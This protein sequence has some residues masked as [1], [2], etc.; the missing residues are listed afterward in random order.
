MKKLM[1]I[2]LVLLA[3]AG[4]VCG[5]GSPLYD[6]A[7]RVTPGGISPAGGVSVMICK[8]GATLTAGICGPP[9]TTVY[10]CANFQSVSCTLSNPITTDTNGNFLVYVPSGFYEV[11]FFGN[12]ITP[13][14]K[15][16]QASGRYFSGTA[17]NIPACTN[18][19]PNALYGDL[20]S[21]VDDT[22]TYKCSPSG[23]VSVLTAGVTSPVGSPSPFVFNVD[24]LWK[25]P[26]PLIDIRAFGARAGA[27]SANTSGTPTATINSGSNSVTLTSSTCTA[28][29]QCFFSNINN[30]GYG[31]GVVIYGAGA[32]HS[33]STPSAPTLN[34]GILASDLGVG[35]SVVGP[36]GSNTQRC[37]VIAARDQNQGLTAKS[38]ES[39]I[40]TYQTLGA[41]T[42]NATATRSNQQIT[43]TVSSHTLANLAMVW[44]NSCSDLT[45]DGFFTVAS[46]TGT[47]LVVN[48]GY[49]AAAA[50]PGVGVSATGCVLTQWNDVIV[51]L[52][53]FGTG[54]W[55]YAIYE[56]ASS[57]ETLY[58]T[59]NPNIGTSDST[60]LVFEDMGSAIS[61]EA[62][63]PYF[64]PNT[65]PSAATSDSLFCQVGSGGGTTTMTLLNQSGTA[66]NAGTSVS[67][68]IILQDVGFAMN[69]AQNFAATGGGD[70]SIP[71]TGFN[72]FFTLNSFLDMNNASVIQSGG[73]ALNDT[74]EL[75]V[76]S[77]NGQ[78]FEN[79]QWKSQPPNGM[80]GRTALNAPRANPGIYLCGGSLQG[81]NFVSAHTNGTGVLNSCGGG[82][83]GALASQVNFYAP[84][85]TG[86]GFRDLQNVS[87]GGFGFSMYDVSFAHDSLSTTVP[88]A[89]CEF[90]NDSLI[91][92][93]STSG[94]RVGCVFPSTQGN[95]F[96]LVWHGYHDNQMGAGSFG[97]LFE[98]SRNGGNVPSHIVISDM[99]TDSSVFPQVVL[100]SMNGP[101]TGNYN[102]TLAL[103]GFNNPSISGNPFGSV[104]VTGFGGGCSAPTQNVNFKCDNGGTGLQINNN[105]IQTLGANGS[106]GY[107]LGQMSN[108]SAAPTVSATTS[109]CSGFPA[110]GS[111]TFDVVFVDPSEAINYNSPSHWTAPSPASGSVSVDGVTQCFAFTRPAA[112][113]GSSIW[114]VGYNP[115]SAGFRM[116]CSQFNV[117]VTSVTISSL[118][119]C[120]SSVPQNNTTALHVLSTGG[121]FGAE[122][123]TSEATASI[124]TSAASPAV[125]SGSYEGFVTI[126]AGTSSIVVDT[127]AVTSVSGID[128]DFDS[129]VG[130]PLGVTCNTT[131]QQPYVSAR[132]NGVSFTISVPSNFSSNPGCIHFHFRN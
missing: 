75:Y 4:V 55:Q 101:S 124:C 77:W 38:A 88:T 108:P 39:C 78:V 7:Y 87:A 81:I 23:W 52:P 93:S 65:P 37:Y 94:L 102:G 19:V 99:V 97:P 98:F 127:T 8:A 51:T 72:A 21:D 105:T 117:G 126:A 59:S 73:F 80:G 69:A 25:G 110:A 79:K 3:S 5:Q 14:T 104:N 119:Q 95:G 61:Q 68:A 1:L 86:Y 31:D 13:Y 60:D 76:A 112:P 62:S 58:A 118:I 85:N 40:S 2:L 131:A 41:V 123:S 35:Y 70:V 9:V 46:N 132:S 44:V 113:A 34:P 130:T 42:T 84:G 66:C 22:N 82:T 27:A 100:V 111:Y 47:T 90:K 43:Y 106:V 129:S 6:T 91:F 83:V 20:Y 28:S 45:F 54:M 56:G 92:V 18:V 71:F 50:P 120:V 121:Y 107:N 67:G 24:M 16:L 74:M 30:T 89:A 15:V 96:G 29:V 109:G 63:F 48:T 125:C 122:L 57:A 33:M 103:D 116:S 32:P 17:A 64:W 26:D 10:S 11:T 49:S 12:G 115:N 53:A 36:S 114:L 128:V